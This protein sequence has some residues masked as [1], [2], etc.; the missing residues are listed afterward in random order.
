MFALVPEY[1]SVN[2]YAL[3]FYILCVA[4]SPAKGNPVNWQVNIRVGS[5][6]QYERPTNKN[7][8]DYVQYQEL[9]TIVQEILENKKRISYV[10]ESLQVNDNWDTAMKCFAAL[11]PCCGI[12]WGIYAKYRNVKKISEENGLALNQNE[13]IRVADPFGKA[14][15]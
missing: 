7:P 9:K 1:K 8:D 13:M 12:F 15:F 3:M 10:N 11:A 5:S 14:I 2:M 6:G 4:V